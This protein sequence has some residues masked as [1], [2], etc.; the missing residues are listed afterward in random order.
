M[1]RRWRRGVL[2][3]SALVGSAGAVAAQP[4]RPDRPVTRV[5]GTPAGGA[6]VDRVDP[7]RTGCAQAPLP[8]VR[9]HA[10]WRTAVKATL[11]HAPLVDARGV[12]YLV[13]SRGEAVAIGDDG[14]ERW[15]LATGAASPSAPALLSDDTLTF[16]DQAGQVVAVRDGHLRWRAHAGR[17]DPS[18]AVAPL[19]LDLGGVM[20]AAGGDLVTYDASG[21]ETS[22]TRVPDTVAA[23]LVAAPGRVLAIGATGAVW[24]WAPGALDA[25]R[26]GT[27]ESP[28]EGSA[29]LAGDDTLLAVTH[30]GTRLTELSLHDG[31]TRTRASSAGAWW[32]GSPAVAGRLTVVQA[33]TPSS[34]LAV[35]FDPAGQELGSALL[36]SQALGSAGDAGAL[37]LQQAR[38]S[39]IVVDTGSTA[40]FATTTGAVGAA[41]HLG[42]PDGSVEVLAGVCSMLPS[43]GPA[44]PVAGMAPLGPEAVV[45]ACHHGEV[46]AVAGERAPR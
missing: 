16:V 28:I 8:E 7:R 35:A 45:V 4:L 41:R 25:S 10:T 15:Q 6:R 38:P 40:V 2:V 32:P 46:V 14:A 39:P 29:A 33:I 13:G 23:P 9:L 22:R 20:A 5:V 42:Q 44:A 34:E 19:A 3:G 31:A 37:L 26:I 43:G 12:A 27:F 11:E 21:Q 36:Q 17:P 18:Y 1:V 30:G 24:S